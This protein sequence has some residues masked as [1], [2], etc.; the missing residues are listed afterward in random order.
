[1]YIAENM[2]VQLEDTWSKFM[3]SKST[4]LVLAKFISSTIINLQI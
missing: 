3:T 4:I 2:G 1:M